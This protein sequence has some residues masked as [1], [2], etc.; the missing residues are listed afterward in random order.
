MNKINILE[1]ILGFPN[2]LKYFLYDDRKLT[3]TA[4]KNNR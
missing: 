2:L 3:K 4:I 1:D